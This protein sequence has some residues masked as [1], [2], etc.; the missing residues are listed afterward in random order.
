[1]K[2]SWL[3]LRKGQRQSEKIGPLLS[4]NYDYF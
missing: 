3:S 1:L 4:S 2:R